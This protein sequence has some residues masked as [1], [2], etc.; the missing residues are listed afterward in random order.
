MVIALSQHS[1]RCGSSHGTDKPGEKLGRP[2]AVVESEAKLI[3]VAL[4]MLFAQA[5]IGSQKEELQ[6]GNQSVR[7]AQSATAFVKD[8]V[9]MGIPLT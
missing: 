3:E 5:M 4:Q 2:E 9:M 7:P 1:P 6:I 8:L